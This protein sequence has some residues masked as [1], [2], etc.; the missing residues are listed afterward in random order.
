[1]IAYHDFLRLLLAAP[2][3][4]ELDSYLAE[5]GGSVPPEALPLLEPI[6]RMSHD[7][8]TIKSIADSVGLSLR[9]LAIR[10]GLPYR[11]VQDWGAGL[12]NPPAW[13]LPLIAY[14]VLSDRVDQDG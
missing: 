2:E 13:Q 8:L 1:M 14:A 5:E 12:R 10:Y 11:T 9:Q 7:G 4:C 6:Y 3:C